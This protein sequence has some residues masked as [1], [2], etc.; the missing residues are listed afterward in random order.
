VAYGLDT[1]QQEYDADGNP[2]PLV[3]LTQQQQLDAVL[4]HLVQ[5]INAVSVGHQGG[6]K[7]EAADAEVEAAKDEM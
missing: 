5:H 2:L 1:P 3:P 7:R 6:L 4:A